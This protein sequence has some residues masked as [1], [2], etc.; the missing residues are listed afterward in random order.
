MRRIISLVLLVTVFLVAV[1]APAFA[2]PFDF[3]R[4]IGRALGKAAGFIIQAP[5]RV[6]TWAT[7]WMGPVLGPVAAGWLAGR[8]LTNRELG[9]IFARAREVQKVVEDIKFLDESRDKLKQAYLDDAAYHKKVAKEYEELVGQIK[10]NPQADDVHKLVEVRLLQDTHRRMATA[11]EKRAASVNNDDVAKLLGKSVLMRLLGGAKKIVIHE[12]A[13]EVKRLIDPNIIIK[14]LQ[15]GMDPGTVID[16]IIENDASRLLKAKGL[17][18]PDGELRDRL[19]AALKEELRNNRDFFKGNWRAEVDRIVAEIA[20]ETPDKPETESAPTED[21]M[22]LPGEIEMTYITLK[23]D[24]EYLEGTGSLK[25]DASDEN[26][27]MLTLDGTIAVAYEDAGEARVVT[28]A[29]PAQD[30]DGVP[31]K[32]DPIT[33]TLEGT[34]TFE[35]FDSAGN[36]T[37]SE[38]APTVMTVTLGYDLAAKGEVTLPPC[39]WATEGDPEGGG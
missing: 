35:R 6:A 17:D 2:G 24:R 28:A 26:V 4:N 30:V 10:A 7:K 15:G 13:E 31:T 23:G 27:G 39:S 36:L 3:L 19:K 9:R 18:D 5:G 29:F 11:L 14:F 22:E 25:V 16:L 21:G 1:P 34:A 38:E 32:G 8:M 12:L 37:S 20:A 33:F